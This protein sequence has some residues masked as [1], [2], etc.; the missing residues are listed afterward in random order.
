MS[1]GLNYV[2]TICTKFVKETV[3][4]DIAAARKWVGY[5]REK[6]TFTQSVRCMKNSAELAL[7]LKFK[8]TT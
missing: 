5:G 3:I 8:R 6:K 1:D 4:M 2:C 7:K